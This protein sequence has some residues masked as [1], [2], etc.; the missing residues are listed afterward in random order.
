MRKL[1]RKKGTPIA[2]LV[3]D[4]EKVCTGTDLTEVLGR[5]ELP[6]DETA[7]WRRDLATAR[8][9]LKALTDPRR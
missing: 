5:V 6:Q 8:K 9:T 2:R 4:D 3:P 7:A 1:M